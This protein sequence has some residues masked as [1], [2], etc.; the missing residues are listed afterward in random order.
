M[1]ISLTPELEKYV[2]KQVQS[3]FYHSSSEV[4]RAALRLLIKSTQNSNFE[5][6]KIWLDQEIQIGLDQVAEGKIVSG[7]QV[8]QS[9][10]D[11][12]RKN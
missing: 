4:I 12:V 2:N 3:G 1:N 8:L 10:K 6:Y 11:I 5:N 9:L 7:D